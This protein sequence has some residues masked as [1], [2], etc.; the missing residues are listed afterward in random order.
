[1]PGAQ[2][3]LAEDDVED[4]EQKYASGG[5][6]LGCEGERGVGE[7]LRPGDAEAHGCQ[8]EETHVD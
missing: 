5:E 3:A 6:Y 4:V 1:M 2:Q 7:V 8:A